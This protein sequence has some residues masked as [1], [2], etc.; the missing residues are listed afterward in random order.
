[1]NTAISHRGPDGSGIYQNSKKNI[2]LGHRRLSIIDLS[3]RAS[4]PMKSENNR[5]IIL[6]NG[7]IYNHIKIKKELKL[8]YWRS[9]SDTE[10]L[11]EACSI[12]GLEKTLKKING[13]FSFVLWDKKLE[14]LYLITDHLAKKPIYWFENEKYF[15]FASELKSL[16]TLPD[17]KKEI[18]HEAINQYLYQG[19][20]SAPYSIY[21][22]TFKIKAKNILK[23]SRNSNPKFEVYDYGQLFLKDTLFNNNNCKISKLEQL[24]S[25]S[26]KDRLISDVPIG[27]FISGGVD[28]TLVAY[29][30]KKYSSKNISTFTASFN[31]K[32]YDESYPAFELANYLNTNHYQVNVDETDFFNLINDLPRVYDEPFSDPSQIP[33]HFLSKLAKKYVKVILT[34]DGGDELFG[35]YR[36]HIFAFY[37][38]NFK[39]YFFNVNPQIAIPILNLI[40]YL[41]PLKD[42]SLLNIQKLIIALKS[43]NLSDL[44]YSLTSKLAQPIHFEN[45]KEINY[46]SI[47]MSISI[48]NDIN[49]LEKILE[50][51]RI[52]YLPNN[53]LVKTD[54]MSMSHGLEVRNPLLDLRLINLSKKISFESNIKFGISKLPL[55]KLLKKNIPDY[56]VT[57]RKHPFLVPISNWLRNELYETSKDL[58]LNGQLIDMGYFK[59]SDIEKI[60]YLHKNRTRNYEEFLW[61]IFMFENWVDKVHN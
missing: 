7:E 6:F 32:Q 15:A 52:N 50:L 4:Q 57:K 8:N 53:I 39:K 30:A 25:V 35:G 24:I 49:N 29:Y 1:M 23:V 9:T 54:R 55:R 48:N 41:L 37:F 36:R 42:M 51:D 21:K 22:N 40:S 56:N 31:K 11:L 60:F 27:C 46:R 14:T 33:L 3:N 2:A 45:I 10:V 5:W 19:Y 16:M 18:N 58:V 38:K 26:V 43:S 61:N 44:Y 34:G 13:M 12:W 28:S 17:F 59:K 20:I 47:D